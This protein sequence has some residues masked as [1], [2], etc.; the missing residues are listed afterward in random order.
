MSETKSAFD[1]VVNIKEERNFE[2]TARP[3]IEMSAMI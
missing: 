2:N 3:I 1:N